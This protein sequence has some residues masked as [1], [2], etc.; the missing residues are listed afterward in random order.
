MSVTQT[1]QIG[2]IYLGTKPEDKG[3]TLNIGLGYHY[4]FDYFSTIDLDYKDYNDVRLYNYIVTLNKKL[5]DSVY[6][7]IIGGISNI[8]LRKKQISL[9]LSDKYGKEYLYGLQLGYEYLIQNNYSIYLQYRYSKAKHITSLESA[10]VA[11]NL[12]RDD[13]SSFLFGFKW[14]FDFKPW[15]QN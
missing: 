3:L 8:E 2:S 11:S 14:M 1:D 7:G 4:S 9:P 6:L 15:L 5:S 12:I 13:Y 10:P